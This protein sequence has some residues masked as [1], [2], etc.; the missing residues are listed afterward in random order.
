[1]ISTAIDPTVVAYTA[2]G[3]ANVSL[4]FRVS[5]EYILQH[6]NPTAE[7]CERFSKEAAAEFLERQI[8]ALNC[9]LADN[10]VGLAFDDMMDLDIYVEESK[11][12]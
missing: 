1:M 11:V 5:D 7:R 10:G 8:K 12:Y 6:L 4:S 3:S 2:S 9:Y